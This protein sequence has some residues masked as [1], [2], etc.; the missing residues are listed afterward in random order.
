MW[1]IRIE[2]AH[3]YKTALSFNVCFKLASNNIATLQNKPLQSLATLF[4]QFIFRL[5]RTQT[6]QLYQIDNFILTINI[7]VNKLKKQRTKQLKLCYS[8]HR[9]YCLVGKHRVYYHKIIIVH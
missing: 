5:L 3:L 9:T 8:K 6:L 7:E 1:Y 4:L 2:L